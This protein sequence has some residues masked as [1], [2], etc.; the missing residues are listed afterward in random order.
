[1]GRRLAYVAWASRPCNFGYRRC[2]GETPMPRKKNSSARF[3]TQIFGNV[4]RVRPVP[5]AEGKA[6]QERE[7]MAVSLKHRGVV[8]LV[9][10]GFCTAAFGQLDLLPSIPKGDIA[11]R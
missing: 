9:V 2:T 1:M 4:R 5:L 6:R 8:A 7:T 3:K 10:L 11:V